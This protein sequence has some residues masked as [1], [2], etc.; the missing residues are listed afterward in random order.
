MGQLPHVLSAHMGLLGASVGPRLDVDWPVFLLL[1]EHLLQG[2]P[3]GEGLQARHPQ[4][5]FSPTTL[6][7]LLPA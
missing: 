5:G 2:G 1:L 3:R 7:P 4:A 6:T